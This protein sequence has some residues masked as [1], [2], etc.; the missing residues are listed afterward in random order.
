M[1]AAV[2]EADMGVDLQEVAKALTE[3]RVILFS[4]A[5][6]ELRSEE[7]I[8][9]R[10]QLRGIAPADLCACMDASEP[11][12]ELGCCSMVN[13]CLNRDMDP[14]DILAE[15]GSSAIFAGGIHH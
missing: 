12:D 5:E 6:R 8:R 9:S 1:N 14:E 3:G 10:R 4:D 2:A 11:C 15:F 7:S 13:E